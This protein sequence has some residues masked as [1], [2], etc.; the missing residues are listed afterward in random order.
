MDFKDKKILVS[1]IARS[2]ISAALTLKN[3]GAAVT[4]QDLKK[5]DEFDDEILSLENKGINLYLGNN[6]DNIISIFDLIIVSPGIPCD[7]PFFEKANALSIPIWSEIELGY[8][9]C[10]NPII[11][12]TGTNGKTTTTALTGQIIKNYRPSSQIVGN[13]GVPFT[14]KVLELASDSFVIAEISSFQLETIKEFKPKISAVLNITPDHLNRHNTVENYTRI[15]ER[16]FENQDENDFLILNYDDEACKKMKEHAHCKTIFFSRLHELQEGIFL[17]DKNIYAKLNNYDEIILNIDELN[18]LGNHNV[19]NAMAAVAICI[20][21]NIPI[22]IIKATLKEFKAVEHRIEYVT[23]INNVEYYNDSKG[24]NPDAA[25]KSIEAMK[26]PILLIGG[27]YDKGSDFSAW[28]NSF[29]NKVK[30]LVV[31]GE[32]ADKI[33]ETAKKYNFNNYCKASTLKEAVE[34]CYN[35]AENGDCVLLSPACASWDMF[36]SYEQRGDLFKEF[37]FN[38]GR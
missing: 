27:G 28:I 32:V 9:L 25:I 17:K 15:K 12:I 23:T 8:K 21:A 2:G 4:L 37:V 22:D 38:L 31:I 7:L 14:Q 36:D 10:N 16:I 11:A 26:R 13:I 20:C 34:I 33:I 24:T 1:G 3:L 30:Y 6:P 29:G 19:E 35:K 18:I 5:R